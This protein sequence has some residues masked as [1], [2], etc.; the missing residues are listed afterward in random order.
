MTLNVTPELGIPIEDE[1][2]QVPLPERTAALDKT[3]AELEKHGLDTK[4]DHCNYAT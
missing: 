3:V 4:P 2:K 1:I